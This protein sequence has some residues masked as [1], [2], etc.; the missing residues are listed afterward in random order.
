MK[1]LRAGRYDCYL[2][3]FALL[4]LGCNETTAPIELTPLPLPVGG[5]SSAQALPPFV[6]ELFAYPGSNLSLPSYGFAER[7]KAEVRIEGLIEVSS[8]AHSS[9]QLNASVGAKGVRSSNGECA[10]G[11][12]LGWSTTFGPHGSCPPPNTTTYDGSPLWIDTVSVG[13]VYNYGILYGQPLQ[14]GAGRGPGIVEPAFSPCIS[15]QEVC[16]GYAGVQTIRLTPLA[17]QLA[18]FPADTVAYVGQTLGFSA[19]ANPSQIGSHVI[20]VY[21]L[22]WKWIPNGG[23]AVQPPGWYCAPGSSSPCQ[24]YMR[25]SGLVELT[26]RV[27]GVVQVDSTR[28]TIVQPEV[29]ISLQK[30]LMNPS[31][32]YKYDNDSLYSEVSRQIITV[33]VTAA[34][35]RFLNQAV[36]LVLTAQEGYGGH[37]NHPA[38]S[39]PKGSF[40]TAGTPWTTGTPFQT[41][42][43]LNTGSTGIDTVSFIAPDPS[44]PVSVTGTSAGARPDTTQ[45]DVKV[46]GLVQLPLND[47]K[48]DTT[49]AKPTHPVN[50][51]GTPVHIATLRALAD[52]FWYAFGKKLTFNDTSLEFGGLYDYKNTWAPP[53]KGHRRGQ[54]TDV[55]TEGLGR[56]E[57]DF[58]RLTWRRKYRGGF[59]DETNTTEPHYHLTK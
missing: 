39:K 5:M 28:I 56:D 8:V 10:V 12:S 2:V 44:G 26:A 46:L 58:M 22:A 43:Q 34:N 33:S 14:G 53:H 50:H 37:V 57:K 18:L 42:I 30:A 49:G 19:R 32:R 16:H 20:P 38:S 24:I 21:V 41:T 47:P 1:P 27:N 15:S 48:Y 59:R 45:I 55:R 25:E 9:F 40:R 4:A 35:V 11:V 7:V 54:N 17:S 52:D 29:Q 51:Y 31:I 3:L 36:T 13:G 6:G 23:T